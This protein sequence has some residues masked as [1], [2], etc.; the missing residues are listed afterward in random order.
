MYVIL[1]SCAD[2][3]VNT[4]YLRVNR[5]LFAL[6]GRDYFRSVVSPQ[7]S[8]PRT[9]IL[10]YIVRRN[11]LREN[12]GHDG[13]NRNS[14]GIKSKQ[15][16]G[17]VYTKEIGPR[18][19]QT[20]TAEGC[21]VRRR[22]GNWFPV[23]VVCVPHPISHPITVSRG[24]RHWRY[25]IWIIEK[26]VYRLYT[27]YFHIINK[28]YILCARELRST[29]EHKSRII[30]LKLTIRSYDNIIWTLINARSF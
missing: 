30:L 1:Q 26:C 4:K 29:V 7:Q 18:L 16:P 9:R 14:G 2:E 23:R 21:F 10:Y 11:Q 6:I 8:E 20:R 13:F 19:V 5:S 3:R 12:V 28:M 24:K 27:I 15:L 25:L 22:V 17:L